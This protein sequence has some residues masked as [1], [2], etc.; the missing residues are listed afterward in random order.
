MS[1]KGLSNCFIFLGL[2]LLIPAIGAL[3][4]GDMSIQQQTCR[5]SCWIYELAKAVGGPQMFKL[6]SFIVW[7]ALAVLCFLA[8]ARLRKRSR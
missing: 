6:V 3:F 5:S 4:F 2:A 8:A 7:G 1:D